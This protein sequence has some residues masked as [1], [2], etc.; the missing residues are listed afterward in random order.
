MRNSTTRNN[1]TAPVGRP[2]FGDISLPEVPEYEEELQPPF[3]PF[4]FLLWFLPRPWRRM[5]MPARRPK[6][7][8]TLFGLIGAV[9]FFAGFLYVAGLAFWVVHGRLD[10]LWF[11]HMNGD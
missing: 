11:L 5:L 9:I 7:P 2:R 4:V 10:W 6:G 3:F 8:P 1:A